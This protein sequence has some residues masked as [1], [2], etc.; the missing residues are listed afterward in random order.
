MTC[1]AAQPANE[2]RPVAPEQPAVDASAPPT[3]FTD[4]RFEKP[5][6]VRKITVKG[7]PPPFATPSAANGPK[8]VARPEGAWPQVPP[9][10]QVDLYAAGLDDPREIRTAP[11]GDFFVTEMS[12]GVVRVFR[13]F[14]KTG[15]PNRVAVFA[16]GLDRPFGIDFYPRGPDPQW[17][18]IGNNGSVV[19]FPYR[20]GDL[21]ARGSSEHIM[22]LP[23]NG[24]A[25]RD[26]RFSPDGR[27]LFVSV[28][29]ASNVDDTDTHPEEKNRA[30]ILEVN[31]DGTGLRIYA[32]GI[33]NPS[34]MAFRPQ[35][36]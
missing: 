14:T 27:K 20:N 5:G 36:G 19:R 21:Q 23:S 35:D 10:F 13:G 25:T 22:D 1:R 32:S 17:V 26:I 30:D 28:G 33:R 7:L 11:N 9:G 24:H 31:P 3:P 12:A 16:T 2:S 15:K 29:S 18:Y 34:A 4:Y 6:Q 8:K